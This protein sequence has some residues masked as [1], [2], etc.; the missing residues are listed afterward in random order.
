[1]DPEVGKQ[2]KKIKTEDQYDFRVFD[3]GTLKFRDQLWVP[4]DRKLRL[5]ILKEAHIS[6]LAIH[7]GIMKIYRDLRL[8]F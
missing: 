8:Y 3:H 7:P 4:D 6:K 5:D 2:K 1:M